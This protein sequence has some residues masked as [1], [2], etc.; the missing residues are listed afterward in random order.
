MNKSLLAIRPK[1]DITTHYLFHWAGQ[2]VNLAK[3][4]G[5]LVL[6]LAKAR[7]NKK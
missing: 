1:D 4:K 5:I 3:K 6:D 7:A 2:I